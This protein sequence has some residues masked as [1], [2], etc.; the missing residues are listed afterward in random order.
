MKLKKIVSLALAGIL[1]VSMLAGCGDNGD[2]NS[3]V[4]PP[5]EDP[6]PASAIADALNDQLFS[7]QAALLSFQSDSKLASFLN[8]IAEDDEDFEIRDTLISNAARPTLLNPAAAGGVNQGNDINTLVNAAY[9]GTNPAVTMTNADILVNH[10]DNRA[11]LYVYTVDGSMQ[12]INQIA[13]AVMN[14]TANNG[15]QDHVYDVAGAVDNG[16]VPEQTDY[17]YKGYAEMVKITNN[18]S[19]DTAWVVAVL[20]EQHAVSNT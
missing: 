11:Y 18:N 13:R 3:T 20:V 6:T 1:A 17:E 19:S 10:D 9:N 14:G 8:R 12:D 2:S 4:T 5:V 15:L 7:K 16:T